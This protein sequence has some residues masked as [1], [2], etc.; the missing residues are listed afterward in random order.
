MHSVPD[1]LLGHEHRTCATQGGQHILNTA[2]Q[3][4]LSGAGRQ[5][6]AGLQ[7]LPVIATGQLGQLL[8]IGLNQRGLVLTRYSRNQRRLG[9]CGQYCD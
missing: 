2:T 6:G 9:L 3:Q 7:L 8:G 5:L 1:T 4:L